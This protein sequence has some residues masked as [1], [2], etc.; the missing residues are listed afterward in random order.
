[1]CWHKFGRW[2]DVDM[3]DIPSL[4]GIAPKA[5]PIFVKQVIKQQRRCSKCNL[6]RT[7]VS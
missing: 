5:F 4:P 2:E 3:K 7:R 6:V 1:M